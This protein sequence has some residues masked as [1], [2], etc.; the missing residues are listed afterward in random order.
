MAITLQS[1]P[2]VPNSPLPNQSSAETAF[3]NNYFKL[4][5]GGVLS[6]RE[7]KALSIV[8]LIHQL[9][10]VRGINYVNNQRALIQDASVFTNNLPQPIDLDTAFAI[11]DW[12]NGL[13]DPNLSSDL[14]ALRAGEMRVYAELSEDQ[15][16]RIMILLELQL[17]E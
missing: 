16:N 14:N 7:R 4:C 12:D 8:G 11:I 1:I 5:Q 9:L 3:F 2:T 13:V 17:A 6:T 10:I 15:L